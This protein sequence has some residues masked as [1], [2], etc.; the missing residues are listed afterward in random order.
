MTDT[1]AYKIIDAAEWREAMA[2]GV[3]A[4]SAVDIADGYIHLSTAAQLD[5]TARKHYAGR[6]N[7]MLLAVD[8]AA[9]EG[10]VVWEESRGGARFPHIYGDLPVSAVTEARPFTVPA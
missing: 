8:L 1:T 2:E 10:K 9:L 5:E 6:Q 3:Y 7:L 4:G